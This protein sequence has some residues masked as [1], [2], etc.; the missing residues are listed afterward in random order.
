M[1]RFWN[2]IDSKDISVKKKHKRAFLLLALCFGFAGLCLW[3]IVRPWALA[4][5]D[6]LFC[7]V[8]YP[9]VASILVVFFYEYGHR[10]H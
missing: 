2:Y 4:T 8:F 5:L 9:V 3:L 1:K 7:F 10:F 6:W